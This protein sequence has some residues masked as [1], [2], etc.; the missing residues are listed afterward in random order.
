MRKIT[1]T[2]RGFRID[3]QFDPGFEAQEIDPHW[4]YEIKEIERSFGVHGIFNGVF[5]QEYV[6]ERCKRNI[7][8]ERQR[9]KIILHET[10]REIEK[11]RHGHKK[12]HH[13]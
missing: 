3:I 2:Y 1:E 6:M 4:Q 12:N 7:R 9:R 5:N 10:I 11:E 8:H 13:K